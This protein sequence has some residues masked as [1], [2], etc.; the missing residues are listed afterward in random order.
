MTREERRRANQ[1]KRAL[2]QRRVLNSFATPLD[3]QVLTIPQWAALN[4]F[5]ERTAFRILD[6]AN[7]PRVVQL[8]AKRI[9]IRVGDNRIWQESRARA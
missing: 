4:G 1:R 6:G 8:S 2:E 5:S 9:G 7:P 3:D